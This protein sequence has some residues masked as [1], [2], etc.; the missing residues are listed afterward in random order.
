MSVSTTGKE[1]EKNIIKAGVVGATA[2]TVQRYGSAVKEHVVA[3][4]GSDNEAAIQLKKSLSSIS[5]SKVNSEY[6]KQNLKQQAGFSAEVKE[7]ANA[8]A[9]KIIDKDVTKKIR[10]DDL[11]RVNDPL[12]DHV[13][14]DSSG[15]IITGSE[16]QM[17][18]V[19]GSPKEALQK[20]SSKKFSKYLNNDAK[21]EVPSNYYDGILQEADAQIG[22]LQKQLD[23]QLSK[24]NYDT[25]NSLKKKIEDYQKI[26]N[27]LRKS[28]VSTD[29][30]MFAR[31]HPKLS[32]A[33]DIAKLSHRS[34]METAQTAGIIG[35][36]I[37]IIQNLVAVAKG[38][39]EFDN[40]IKNVAKD[41]TASA[42]LGYGTGFAGASLKGL[43]Q[44]AGSG[45]VRTLSKT[46][47]PGA[48]VMVAVSATK[49]M[50]R[51][52]KGELTGLECFEE[53]GQQGTGMISSSMFTVIGQAV[54]PIPVVGGM[55]GGMLGYA[56]A[57][58]SYGTLLI[59]LKDSKLAHEERIQIEQVCEEHIQM[60][61]AYRLELEEIIS[62]YLVSNMELF[63]QSF[64]NMKN[65]LGIG[66]IDGFISGANS[67]SKALGKP[68][69]FENLDE[70]SAIMDSN[71]TFKL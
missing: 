11:G 47:L 13:E 67:I 55:L 53:L 64:D 18:F 34:G 70:F 29:D 52:F 51:Y 9:E 32:T 21:I 7:T 48:V 63:Q 43:M 19:G 15:T 57:S 4:S 49:T 68:P 5:R 61:R 37:S 27:N 44:N 20:L 8:N 14:L 24:S 1:T 33:K 28:S 59:S 54:I 3:Y 60:I 17:K 38:D 10:T 69:Q 12:Y 41:T 6:K 2:E 36:S 46:N 23:D 45:T 22:K 16:S 30:A 39:I 66:N 26:K 40:A 58:A 50:N 71:T 25:A 31:L 62:K 65:S 42:A 56:I 35:G